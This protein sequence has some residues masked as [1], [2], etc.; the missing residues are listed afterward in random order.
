[1]NAPS[2]PTN[3]RAT[4]SKKHPTPL[5]PLPQQ[6]PH[7]PAGKLRPAMGAPRPCWE[8]GPENIR[9]QAAGDGLFCQRPQPPALQPPR[10]AAPES[11]RP[12]C[13][14]GADKPAHQGKFPVFLFYSLCLLPRRELTGT[15]TL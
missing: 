7:R 3:P 8:S 14:A 6:P 12:D 5:R 2:I 1:M 15:N 11:P 10:A 4:R 9:I 13:S